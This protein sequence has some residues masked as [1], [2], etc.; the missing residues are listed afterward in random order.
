MEATA[1]DTPN[2]RPMVDLLNADT[3]LGQL[4]RDVDR[5]QIRVRA[6]ERWVIGGLGGASVVTLGL[7]ALS[8]WRQF[9]R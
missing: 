8:V 5:L 6:L 9:Q 1:L 7:A 3:R 4:R 2:D